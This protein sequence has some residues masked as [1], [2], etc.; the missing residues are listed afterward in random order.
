MTPTNCNVSLY[1]VVT[2]PRSPPR[3]A[4]RRHMTCTGPIPEGGTVAFRETN[5]DISGMAQ[6]ACCTAG[7][8]D[9]PAMETHAAHG[10]PEWNVSRTPVSERL[11]GLL[12]SFRPAA[13]ESMMD[14]KDPRPGARTVMAS[15]SGWARIRD[16]PISR[17]VV[18]QVLATTIAPQRHTTSRRHNGTTGAGPA[19]APCPPPHG[20][21]PPRR[22]PFRACRPG[23][24][25]AVEEE[26]DDLLEAETRLDG[27]GRRRRD[28]TSG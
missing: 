27:K 28:A 8:C 26:V 9:R 5:D 3:R 15:D 6:S 21:G 22:A 18:Q 12:P 23:R 14:A 11:R 25:R 10:G 2:A 1:S 19:V 13:A 7:S 16:M 20:A 24:G 17:F 4:C